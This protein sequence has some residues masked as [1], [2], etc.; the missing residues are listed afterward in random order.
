MMKCL[1]RALHF[2]LF[3]TMLFLWSCGGGGSTGGTTA[4]D[5][6]YSIPNIPVDPSTYTF[7]ASTASEET[8]YVWGLL[9]KYQWY[10]NNGYT[11][12]LP[13]SAI[14]A[15]LINKSLNNLPFTNS[16]Y[17]E[18]QAAMLTI[19]NSTDYQLGLNKLNESKSKILACFPAFLDY[20]AKWAIHGWNFKIFSNYTVRLTLYGPGGSYESNT[21]TIIMLT[22]T[23]GTFGRGADPTPT[24]VHE[25][26]HIAIEDEV[27]VKYGVTQ[28]VKE[29][30]VDKF[31]YFHFLKVLTNYRMQSTGDIS[32]DPYVSQGDS[33]E[34]LPYYVNRY[35][36]GLPAS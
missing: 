32:I 10:Q 14:V 22:Y 9:L 23:N 19:Y 11:I 20:Q 7:R 21:G 31:C 34:R 33:W 28:Q 6:G 13:N 2:L 4:S 27:I 26:A 35:A 16:D 1:Y 12:S 18:L 15:N 30:I 29:R 17:S 24:V 3:G 8:E 25:T 5:S 36:S